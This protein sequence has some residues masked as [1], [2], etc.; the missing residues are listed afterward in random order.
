MVDLDDPDAVLSCATSE[1]FEERAGRPSKWS[2]SDGLVSLGIG[3][4]MIGVG[5]RLEGREA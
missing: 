4:G 3:L 5:S 1:R 2:L